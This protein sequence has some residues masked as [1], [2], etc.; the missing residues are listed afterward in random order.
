[1]KFVKR[2]SLF[3]IYTTTVFGMGFAANM[4]IMEFFYPGENLPKEPR[5]TEELS[6]Q[7]SVREEPV[8]NADT[9]YMVQWY[10]VK[11]GEASMQEEKAPDKFMGLTREKLVSEIESYNGNPSL[12]DM[13]RGFTYMELVSFSPEKTVVRKSFEPTE[14]KGFFLLNENHLVVVY[15]H[16]LEHVYMTTDILVETLPEHIQEE[17]IHMKYIETE[18]ELFNFLESYSS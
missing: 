7:V 12:T 5:V 1:M 15:D 11:T 6:V 17:V 14:E 13:E 2:I 8:I 10:N 9:Q 4:A 16:R 18:S 3:F